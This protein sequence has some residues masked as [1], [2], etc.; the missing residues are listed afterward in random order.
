MPREL[1][2]AYG[3]KLEFF[4]SLLDSTSETEA[5]QANGAAKRIKP[6]DLHEEIAPAM[7]AHPLGAT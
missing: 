5:V 4:R 7:T 1:I 2:A 3:A 6:D